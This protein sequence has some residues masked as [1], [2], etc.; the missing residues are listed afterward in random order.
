MKLKLKLDG[1][2]TTLGNTQ[3]VTCNLYRIILYTY[4]KNI[5]S[6][7]PSRSLY[8]DLIFIMGSKY[9][10][11]HIINN[12]RTTVHCDV[13]DMSAAK[14]TKDDTRAT[15]TEAKCWAIATKP[16]ETK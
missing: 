5:A 16:N 15:T 8:N 3:I 11:R 12:I 13:S 9:K 4:K 6:Q 2:L 10:K 7:N 1:G 14:T